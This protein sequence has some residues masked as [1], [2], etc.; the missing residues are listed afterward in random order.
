[1]R[2]EAGSQPP[3]HRVVVHHV[4]QR[5]DCSAGRL[6]AQPARQ[7]FKDERPPEGRRGMDAEAYG[8]VAPTPIARGR[9]AAVIDMRHRVH[10][11]CGV[12]ILQA[13]A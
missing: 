8:S 3:M 4:R 7:R 5:G 1:M 9:R 10:R 12:A 13:A 11:P 6:P 2:L